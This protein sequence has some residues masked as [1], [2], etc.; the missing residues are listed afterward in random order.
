MYPR[1]SRSAV[2]GF[3]GFIVI[4]ILWSKSIKSK[5]MDMDWDRDRA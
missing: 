2:R 3:A 1:R 4:V 5:H